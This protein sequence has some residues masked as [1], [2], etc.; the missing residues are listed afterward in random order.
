MVIVKIAKNLIHENFR[1]RYISLKFRWKIAQ[2]KDRPKDR[3]R[4]AG[5]SRV[6]CWDLQSPSP[7]L[8]SPRPLC[9]SPLQLLSHVAARSPAPILNFFSLGSQRDDGDVRPGCRQ[10]SSSPG[11]SRPGV[12][13]GIELRSQLCL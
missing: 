12:C 3:N 10:K 7:I 11:K 13:A 2:A 6:R 4:F 8:K 9:P 5:V 1:I